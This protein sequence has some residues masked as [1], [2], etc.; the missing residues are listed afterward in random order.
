MSVCFLA[1][2]FQWTRLSSSP[3]CQ[4]RTSSGVLWSA[5]ARCAAE[6]SP[7]P[8]LKDSALTTAGRGRTISLESG[9]LIVRL[10]ENRP[11]QSE[12]TSCVMPTGY[13]PTCGQENWFSLTVSPQILVERESSLLFP[14][15]RKSLTDTG[16]IGAGNGR[17]RRSA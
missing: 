5:C 8:G 1:E 13:T 7:S 9:A 3:S 16:A 14:L 10:K 12:K 17:R 15:G 2:S 4:L 6:L 11:K